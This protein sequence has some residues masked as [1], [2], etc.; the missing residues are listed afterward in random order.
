MLFVRIYVTKQNSLGVWVGR[1]E[2][3]EGTG[4]VGWWW[5]GRGRGMLYCYQRLH[6]DTKA[7]TPTIR[8]IRFVPLWPSRQLCLRWGSGSDERK[9]IDGSRYAVSFSIAPPQALASPKYEDKCCLTGRRV[10]NR[11]HRHPTC[12]H[13]S[14]NS[15]QNGV[16]KKTEEEQLPASLPEHLVSAWS[17]TRLWR[18]LLRS[19]DGTPWMQK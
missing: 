13:A 1:G 14:N 3:G 9:G 10:L 8:Q 16:F 15:E 19:S 7:N 18:C 2:E 4:S 6:F 12:L 5:E 17:K 11:Q